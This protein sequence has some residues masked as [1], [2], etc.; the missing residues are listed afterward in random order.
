MLYGGGFDQLGK[1]L[2]AT[3]V[4]LAYS[5]V[6]AGLLGLAV[7]KMMGFRIDEEHE[8]SGIDLV[9]HA[10]TAY[11]LHATSGTRGSGHSLL[12]SLT[13]REVEA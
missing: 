11:D 5:F 12:S 10:E 3:V 7:D 13:H 1:Q 6:M 8:I 4:V 9:I 2:L